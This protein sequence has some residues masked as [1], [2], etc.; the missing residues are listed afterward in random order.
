VPEGAPN[1]L[2]GKSFL[3]TG[4]LDSLERAECEALI[5]KHGGKV[6]KSV[7]KA[8]TYAVIGT[9]PGA[10]KMKSARRALQTSSVSD[11]DGLF[12]LIRSAAI[13]PELAQEDRRRQGEGGRQEAEGV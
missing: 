9:E 4:V 2:A 6:A 11:E 10:S 3:I 8:L 13:S 12:E 5:L 1:C 7:T